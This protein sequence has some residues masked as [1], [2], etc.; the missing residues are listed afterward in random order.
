ME[1]QRCRAK[2]YQAKERQ[3]RRLQ[4]DISMADYVVLIAP[5]G[6]DSP[7]PLKLRSIKLFNNR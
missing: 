3:R 5:A 4:S 6:Y 1:E 2:S 7:L